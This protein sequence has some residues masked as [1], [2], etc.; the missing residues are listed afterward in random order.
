VVRPRRAQFPLSPG[1]FICSRKN[2]GTFLS[3]LRLNPSVAFHGE[4]R[5]GNPLIQ[6]HYASRDLSVSRHV[7]EYRV[8]KGALLGLP[9]K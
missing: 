9:R 3:L 1:I 2:P 4:G 6:F 7:D 5:F 8:A